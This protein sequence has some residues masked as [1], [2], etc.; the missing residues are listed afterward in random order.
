MPLVVSYDEIK[1]EQ[2]KRSAGGSDRPA[3]T[4][5]PFFRATTETPDAPTAF[6]AQYDPGEK[7][8][9]HFHQVDQFQVLVRGKG[10]LGRHEVAPY[11]VHF[12]RAYTPYGPLHADEQSGWTFMTLR[13]RYDPG[14]QRLPGALPKLQQVRDRQPWQVTSMATFAGNSGHQGRARIVCALNYHGAWHER[15]C[16]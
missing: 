3:V 15:R 6:L 1:P 7:S 11:Y 4:N 9:T 16:A 8:C 10:T 2:I 12:A 5:F 13:T 14:A